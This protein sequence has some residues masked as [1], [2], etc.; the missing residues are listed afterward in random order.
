MAENRHLAEDFHWLLNRI[1]WR[2]ETTFCKKEKKYPLVPSLEKGNSR[3]KEL[4]EYFKLTE[5]ERLIFLLAI[6]PSFIAH[7]LSK[8]V[9]RSPD[10]LPLSYGE[11]KNV[12]TGVFIPTGTTA[13]FLLAGNDTNKR[14]ESMNSL[15]DHPLIR[16]E[17]LFIGAE[18]KEEPYMSG[19]LHL[20]KNVFHML[21]GKKEIG[22]FVKELNPPIHESF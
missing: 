20:D 21:S 13:L 15:M 9:R 14:L 2:W 18:K 12:S 8:F 5:E 22:S 1:Y 11:R 19:F 3:Y 6:A 17:L 4:L 16:K 10:Y 7:D